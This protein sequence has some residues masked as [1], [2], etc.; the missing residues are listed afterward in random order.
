MFVHAYSRVEKWKTFCARA[1]VHMAHGSL[2]I[3][4]NSLKENLAFQFLGI[5]ARKVSCPTILDSIYQFVWSSRFIWYPYCHILWHFMSYGKC[6]K[7]SWNVILWHLPYDIKFHK[8]WQ[9][10]YQMNQFDK[11]NWYMEFKSVWQ[12]HFLQNFPK[13]EKTNFPL[14]NS[15][16]L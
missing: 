8:V 2:K 9:Y 10:G 3:Q 16:V 15:F 5:F 12:E 4:R 6:H 14:A 7:M 1:N 11:T 13:T